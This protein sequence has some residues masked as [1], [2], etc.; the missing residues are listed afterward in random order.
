MNCKIFSGFNDAM[1]QK[2]I[3]AWLEKANEKRIEIQF[4]AQ[5]GTTNDLAVSIFYRY[6]DTGT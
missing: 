5:S 3:N 2:E 1:L 4:V 6:P